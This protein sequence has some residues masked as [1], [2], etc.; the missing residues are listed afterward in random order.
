MLPFRVGKLPSSP[1]TPITMSDSAQQAQL[2]TLV[3]ATVCFVTFLGFTSLCK[4]LWPTWEKGEPQGLWSGG[5]LGASL[6]LFCG[7]AMLAWQ[8]LGFVSLYVLIVGVAMAVLWGSALGAW[9]VPRPGTSDAYSFTRIEPFWTR[10]HSLPKFSTLTSPPSP[11]EVADWTRRK[12][13][14]TARW[15]LRV[16]V[17]NETPSEQVPEAETSLPPQR[18]EVEEQAAEGA[19]ETPPPETIRARRRRRAG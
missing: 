8:G 19:E 5:L 2:T 18:R 7:I 1:S 10:V 17:P 12:I 9:M 6:G 16:P 13:A 3:Y 15:A 4:Q 14:D 11:Q